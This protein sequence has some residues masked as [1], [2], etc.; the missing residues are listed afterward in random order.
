MDVPNPE[1]D[2]QEGRR[3]PEPFPAR[4]VLQGVRKVLPSRSCPGWPGIASSPPGWAAAAKPG[5]TRAEGACRCSFLSAALET[6]CNFNNQLQQNWAGPASLS[7]TPLAM[8]HGLDNLEHM[9]GPRGDVEM[10][11]VARAAQAL[12]W[13]RLLIRNSWLRILLPA[14]EPSDTTSSEI[15]CNFGAAQVRASSAEIHGVAAHI[16]NFGLF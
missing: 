7:T 12:F 3:A 6:C 13:F 8:R 4:A 16:S 10:D 1:L 11:P 5:S 2:A 15:S 14:D 9:A